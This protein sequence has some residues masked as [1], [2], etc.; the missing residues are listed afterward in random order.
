MWATSLLTSGYAEEFSNSFAVDVGPKQ[1]RCEIIG[2]N[3]RFEQSG[4]FTTNV[5][6]TWMLRMWDPGFEAPGLVGGLGLAYGYYHD[7]DLT[8]QIFEWRADVGPAYEPTSWL[9]IAMLAFAGIGY[10]DLSVPQASY[11]STGIGGAGMWGFSYGAHAQLS[12]K[13]WENIQV[14]GQLGFRGLYASYSVTENN[15]LERAATISA[16]GLLAGA[17]IDFSF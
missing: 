10:H 1:Y 8:Y 15:T 16:T 3:A 12:V 9:R 6:A 2:N 7:Q 5:H 4:R 14:S 17:S 13:P 11:T